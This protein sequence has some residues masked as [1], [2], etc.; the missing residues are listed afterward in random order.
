MPQ[1]TQQQIAT[2]DGAFV[3]PPAFTMAY[4][5][6]QI[7]R[8]AN[9]PADLEAVIKPL[10]KEILDSPYRDGGW[11][12][13]QVVHH[14]ADSHMQAFAR[15]KLTLTEDSPIIKPYNQNAW[16][17][18]ADC[19]VDTM[20][21]VQLIKALHIRFVA[22]MQSMNEADFSKEY[23]HP[24]YNRN[25]SLAFVTGMYAWHGYHHL[26]QITMFLENQN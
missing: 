21:S 17:T 4:L 26:Q 18:T 6:Q 23:I 10:S 3:A 8:I 19:D 15:F 7:E 13:N 24:E 5:Q 2:A 25:F 16:V 1:Y 14:I 20:V 9:F 11:T 12:L 22:I